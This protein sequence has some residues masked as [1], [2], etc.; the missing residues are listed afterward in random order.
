MALPVKL[1]V[2]LGPNDGTGDSR[3]DAFVKIQQCL[4]DLDVRA[5]LAPTAEDLVG[6]T[7][8]ISGKL[9]KTGDASAT[10]VTPT[11]GVARTLSA[12]A[13]DA[14]SLKDFGG[15]AGSDW[16]TAVNTAQSA[17]PKR[18]PVPEGSYSVTFDQF[19]AA[20]K[21]YAGPGQLALSNGFKDAPW[22][23][24]VTQFKA[25]PTG[26]TASPTD[27]WTAD[28]SQFYAAARMLVVSGATPA[29]T[30]SYVNMPMAAMT[31]WGWETYAGFNANAG[32]HAQGRTGQWM[33][34]FALRHSGQ[35]DATVFN[36]NI[37]ANNARAGATHFLANPAV[38]MYGGNVYATSQA[39]GAYLQGS[40]VIFSDG[41]V[42]VAAIDRVRNYA[43][44]KAATGLGEVWIHDRPQVQG[45][46]GNL[47]ID[48]FY[49]PGGKAKRGL[50]FGGADFSAGNNAAIV[51]QPG[52]RI[53]FGGYADGDAAGLRTVSTSLGFTSIY[54]DAN[55]YL[56]IDAG[57]N[58]KA[59]IL[60][61][62]PT[63]ASG[64]PSGAVWK[65]AANGNVL[66]VAP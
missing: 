33:H 36:F 64:L 12:R 18:I 58:S 50:D 41:G 54:Q 23:T 42:S 3:R 47:P 14:L 17:A 13:V 46:T 52:M 15:P 53:F 35:G 16:T 9:D 59:V 2:G 37:A 51:M 49:V 38:Q 39:P 48:G 65:D 11:G 21:V 26:W 4:D 10:S 40:E 31:R 7:Q 55:G 5:D 8:D 27:Q 25:S 6:V 22:R 61:N 43:R 44:T 56:H 30:N 66:K 24:L 1:N 28:F 45:F 62:L 60:D 34:D 63:S 19:G 57:T 29:T 20:N 32:D